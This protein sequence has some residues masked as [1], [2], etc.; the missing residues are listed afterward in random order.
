MIGRWYSKHFQCFSWGPPW[1]SVLV[2]AYHLAVPASNLKLTST[3]LNSEILSYICHSVEKGRKLTKRGR[4]WLNKK[5]KRPKYYISFSLR[6]SCS[7]RSPFIFCRESTSIN[8]AKTLI[9]YT[10]GAPT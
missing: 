9:T 8:V 2:V 4:V 6:S 7:I 3:L 10:F 1:L 5:T